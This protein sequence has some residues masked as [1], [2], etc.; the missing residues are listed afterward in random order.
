MAVHHVEVEPVD[1][2]ALQLADGVGCPKSAVRMLAAI[3]AR[4]PCPRLVPHSGG[5]TARGSARRSA[6]ALSPI[7]RSRRRATVA[8]GWRAGTLGREL[9]AGRADL[10]ARGCAGPSSRCRRSR[11]I[12]ANALDPSSAL[13]VH[14]VWATGF[15]GMRLT[16]ASWP[17][18]SSAMARGVGRR[19]VD[20][21]DH[22]E[23]VRD[24]PARRARHSRARRPRPRSTG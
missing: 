17:R 13:G 3:R 14:G 7:R 23:L 6:A 9:A 2:G 10:V 11:S 20:A 1:A 22:H 5:A 21:V 18:S 19:V 16:W 15:M 12:A 8:G 24:A 4:P